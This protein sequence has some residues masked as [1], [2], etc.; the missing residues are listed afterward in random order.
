MAIF[1][2][3]RFTRPGPGI[4]KGLERK[5]GVKRF[6]EIVARDSG[7]LMILSAIQT[8][9]FLIP[10]A[11]LLFALQQG[12]PVVMLLCFALVLLYGLFLGPCCTA[13]SH[14]MSKSLR[15]A[16][17]F[18]WEDWK[19]AFRGSVKQTALV[20]VGYT[21]L[22]CIQ[23]IG[24]LVAFE[25]SATALILILVSTILL[26]MTMPY[27]F[28]QAGY[29]ELGTSGLLRNSLLLAF[30]KLP[31][32][33]I[34]TVIPLLLAALCIAIPTTILVALP[35]ITALAMLWQHMWIWSVV[36]ETFHIEAEFQRRN[37]AI[38]AD[39]EKIDFHDPH[40]ED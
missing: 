34:S 36:D 37:E 25:Q 2:S 18:F 15:D 6:F 35:F 24:L 39:V 31:R 1:Q 12:S 16:R 3:D 29:L 20:G 14:A 8:V 9:A 21:A 38:I 11:L 7:I 28:L 10:Y 32:S 30:G 26:H 33:L 22:S 17:E 4:P 40:A 23:V 27:F 13:C 5:R 19:K